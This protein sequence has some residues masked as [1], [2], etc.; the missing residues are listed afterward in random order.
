MQ[1]VVPRQIEPSDPAL[2]LLPIQSELLV[3]TEV[4]K[5][6]IL[7]LLVAVAGVFL[8]MV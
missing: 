8:P 4:I 5:L 7:L 3:S 2:M 1:Q 6:R